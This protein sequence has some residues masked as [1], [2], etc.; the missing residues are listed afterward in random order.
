MLEQQDAQ[1]GDD[2]EDTKTRRLDQV[3]GPVVPK[4]VSNGG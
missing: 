1:P 3:F 2:H 4:R